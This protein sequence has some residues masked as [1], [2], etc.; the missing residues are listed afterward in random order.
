MVLRGTSVKPDINIV[1]AYQALAEAQN[2]LEKAQGQLDGADASGFV[3]QANNP[4]LAPRSDGELDEVSKEHLNEALKQLSIRNRQL[5][6]LLETSSADTVRE[7]Q[8]RK[9]LLQ[10]AAGGFAGIIARTT[11]APIDRVKILMQT[12]AVSGS[13]NKYNGLMQ[14]LRLVIAE[15]GVRGLWRSN[16]ANVVRVAPYS[17]TQFASYDYYKVKL[18][19]DVK[20]QEGAPKP[21]FQE[22][23]MQRILCG[24]LAGLTAT[25]VTHPLD[26]IRLRVATDKEVKGISDAFFQILKEGG[27]INLYRGWVPT[28]V[29]LCPFIA[30]NF[31]AFDTIKKNIYGEDKPST[32]GTLAIGA[33]AGLVAQSV[34]HPLDTIRRRL[35]MKGHTYKGLFDAIKRISAEEGLQGFYRGVVPNAVKIVPNNAIR[36]LVY[37]TL[38]DLFNCN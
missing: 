16:F 9:A 5:L 28:V 19:L 12:Q 13:A 35:Q 8:Y 23:F 34:C 33:S 14:S 2:S 1:K 24:G 6:Q 18:G 3:L 37:T 36:F 17:A 20:R 22:Q 30:V 25:T 11:V 15:D 29:S 26:L 4:L 27:P 10:F 7:T 38:K 21:S 32:L 31:T